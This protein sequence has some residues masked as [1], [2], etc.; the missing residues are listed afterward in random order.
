MSEEKK[1]LRKLVKQK[2][3][4]LDKE[5][6]FSYTDLIAETLFQQ[7][8]WIEAEV[9]GITVSRGNEVETRGIIERA[10]KDGKKIAIPKCFPENK[11]MIFYI[12]TDYSQLEEVYFGLKEPKINET[13]AVN[14]NEIHLLIVPGVVFTEKGYRIGYGG[15]YYDRYLSSFKGATISLLFECQFNQDIPIEKHD[16]PVQ[17]LITEQRTILCD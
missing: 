17:Q 6:I 15:G 10:W 3:S 1:E 8:K 13:V 14:H 7:R 9:I 4:H 11:N 5:Q 12:F 16:I 2:L